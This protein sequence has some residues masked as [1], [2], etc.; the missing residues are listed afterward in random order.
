M[1]TIAGPVNGKITLRGDYFA[2]HFRV[3]RVQSGNGACAMRY[4][5]WIVNASRQGQQRAAERGQQAKQL[6]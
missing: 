3:A 6:Q 2:G 5:L 4:A 1:P